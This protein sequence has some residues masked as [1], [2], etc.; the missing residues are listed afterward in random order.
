LGAADQLFCLSHYHARGELEPGTRL[1]LVSWGRGMH[2][3]CSLLEA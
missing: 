1:A 3:A 2:W